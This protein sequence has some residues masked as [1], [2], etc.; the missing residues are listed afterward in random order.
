M[1]HA[2]GGDAQARSLEARQDLA[3]DGFAH[4]IGLDDR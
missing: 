4:R 2:R 3:D 1:R